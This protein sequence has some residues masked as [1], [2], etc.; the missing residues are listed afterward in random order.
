M[1]CKEVQ[2]DEILTH[3]YENQMEE[4]GYNQVF[5]LAVRDYIP[6]LAAE[7]EEEDKEFAKSLVKEQKASLAKQKA[8]KAKQAKAE[9]PKSRDKITKTVKNDTAKPKNSKLKPPPPMKLSFDD[10][11]DV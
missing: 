6:E 4:I 3:Y 5:E 2:W 7:A 11:E 8:R 10:E 9:A 1:E